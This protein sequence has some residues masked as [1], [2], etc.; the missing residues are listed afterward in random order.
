[1]RWTRPASSARTWLGPRR[2]RL[3]LVDFLVRMWLLNA[4]P[5]LNLPDAVLRKR[6]A[7]ARLVFIFGIAKLLE[8]FFDTGPSG[9]GNRTS[10]RLEPAC[11]RY[12]LPWTEGP[13]SRR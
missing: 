3:R 11:L 7:A 12:S 13:P 10:C 8:L 4:C 5:H 9:G 6:L 2:P 1:M